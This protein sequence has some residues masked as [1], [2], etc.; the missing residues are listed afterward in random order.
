MEPTFK[1]SKV[2]VSPV[3]KKWWQ[4]WRIKRTLKAGEHYTVKDTGVDIDLKKPVLSVK[5]RCEVQVFFDKVKLMG[6]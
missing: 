1:V 3:D 5:D 2:V 6:A 4:F